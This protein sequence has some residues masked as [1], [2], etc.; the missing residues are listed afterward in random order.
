[1][2]DQKHDEP[3]CKCKLAVLQA[4]NDMI[5]DEMPQRY[6]REA[7]TRVYRHHHP[8]ESKE[9]SSLTVESWIHAGHF[10]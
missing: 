4:Y 8:E 1:M 9:L 10:H 7:A 2:C 3:P 6:A 5:G